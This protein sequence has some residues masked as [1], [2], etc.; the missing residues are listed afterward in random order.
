MAEGF[1]VIT[2]VAGIMSLGLELS[3][4]IIAY[5]DAIKHCNGEIN[6]VHRQAKALQNSIGILK[7]VIP[8]I[9]LKHQTIG[10][11]GYSSSGISRAG[12]K[13]FEKLH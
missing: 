3:T 13:G 1:T 12:A 6:A 4:R 10:K 2:S 8:D 11:T 7:N 9:T 5:I